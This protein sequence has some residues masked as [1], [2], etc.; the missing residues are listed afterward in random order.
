MHARVLYSKRKR[1]QANVFEVGNMTNFNMAHLH[2][3][4]LF[5]CTC[6]VIR[7]KN[8]IHNRKRK[9]RN[10]YKQRRLTCFTVRHQ[11]G[12]RITKKKEEK[13][14]R[15]GAERRSLNGSAR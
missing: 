4:L 8:I 11:H 5:M 1:S 13:N 3:Y 7:A 14:V 15:S 10:I 12:N 6:V 2:A 9:K